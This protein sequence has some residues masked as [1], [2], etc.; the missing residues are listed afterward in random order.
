MLNYI[1]KR[2]VIALIAIFVLATVTFFLM[3]LVPGDPFAGPRIAPEIRAALRSYYGLDRPLPEQYVIYMLNLLR[4]DLGLSLAARGHTVTDIIATAFPVSLDLGIR[5]MILSIVFGV[6]FGVVAA[7]RRGTTFDYLTVVLV[8]VGISVPSFVLAG[9]M[10]YYLGVYFRILPIARYETFW[11]TIMPAF[12]LSLGTMATIA[13]YMR[14]SMLEV[15]HADYIKTAFAKGLKPHQ[16]VLRHQIR[17]A[18]CPVLTILGPAVA[19]VLTGSFVVETV[20]AIPG[21]GR[22][23][24][25]AMQNL[26]YTLVMGLTIFFGAFLIAMNFLVD[27]AYGL[28]DPRIRTS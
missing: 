24:V 10:Q 4:G 5:A 3:R 26:D 1:V 22:Y 2:L 25:T 7:L 18:L 11:H 12:A 20:F 27:L 16:V 8:L 28:I 9:L 21:L 15:V 14:S 13:R 23:F 17:N 6:A 19:S